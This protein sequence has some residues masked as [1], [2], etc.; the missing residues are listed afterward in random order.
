MPSE[1][2]HL[3]AES[4]VLWAVKSLYAM[5][6]APR[7]PLLQWLL[8]VLVGEK[9]THVVLKTVIEAAEG[10]YLEPANPRKLN[11]CAMLKVPPSGF[12]CFVSDEDV[13]STMPAEVWQEASCHLSQGGWPLADDPSHKYYVVASWLQD[14]SSKFNEMSFGRVLSIVRCSTQSVGLL[15]HRGGVLVPYAQSEECE[16]RV[17]ACTCKPTHVGPNESYVG[18]WEELKDC[19]LVLL[20]NQPEIEVS[21]LKHLFRTNFGRELSETVFGHQCLSKLLRDQ[22]IGDEFVLDT[23]SSKRTDRYILKFTARKVPLLLADAVHAA[24][25]PRSDTIQI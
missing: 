19:L 22:R 1:M 13:T 8:Q 9:W 17:N 12:T 2:S 23:L 20:G 3:N 18:T 6:A 24:P 11:F 21:Q 14:V 25:V 4:V 10:M 5:E 16:R 7:G 15:G